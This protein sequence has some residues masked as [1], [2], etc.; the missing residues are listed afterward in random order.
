[1]ILLLISLR[2]LQK[3]EKNFTS[4]HY[5]IYK[6]TSICIYVPCFPSLLKMNIFMLPTKT[7]SSTCAEVPTLSCLSKDTT[8]IFPLSPTF[9]MFPSLLDHPL[10]FHHHTNMLLFLSIDKKILTF[11]YPYSYLTPKV[12]LHH[13]VLKYIDPT[14]FSL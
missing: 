8:L 3:S 1:M 9:L 12:L 11:K 6:P 7:D 14:V 13:W 4:S 5:H 2:K 10:Y